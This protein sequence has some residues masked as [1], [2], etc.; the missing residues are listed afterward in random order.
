M[1]YAVAMLVLVTT[2]WADGQTSRPAKGKPETQPTV[3]AALSGLPKGSRPEGGEWNEFTRPKANEWLASHSA[4]LS[5]DGAMEIQ[6]VRID[7][8][9]PK[10]K[11]DHVVAWSVIFNIKHPDVSFD[12]SKMPIFL[13][14][15]RDDD[16]DSSFWFYCDEP[17]ARIMKFLNADDKV[18]T[19]MVI[20]SL[21]VEYGHYVARMSEWKL[22][23]VGKKKIP[24]PIPLSD[25]RGKLQN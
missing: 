3:M 22:I 1:R 15:L 12:G 17:T 2:G 20:G 18:L 19:H 10:D 24:D 4:N 16:V 9:A 7:P 8:V 13:F 11:P 21:R 5:V 25:L 14:P 6:V 23:Q